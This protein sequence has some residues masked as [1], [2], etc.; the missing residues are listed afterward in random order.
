MRVKNK[1][2]KIKG[3]VWDVIEFS[4]KSIKETLGTIKKI[5]HKLSI[6][7]IGLFLIYLVV[8][9]LLKLWK[10]IAFI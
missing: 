7:C 5:T 3:D 9:K 10:R 2:I 4:E 8:I 6:Q 1:N